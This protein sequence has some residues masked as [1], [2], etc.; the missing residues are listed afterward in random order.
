MNSIFFSLFHGK[1]T[2]VRQAVTE[3]PSGSSWVET[4]K[5]YGLTNGSVTVCKSPSTSLWAPHVTLMVESSHVEPHF[6][7]YG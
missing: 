3:A 4:T 7:H 5:A 2:G 6:T 1:A